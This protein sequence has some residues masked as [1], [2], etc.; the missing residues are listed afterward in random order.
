MPSD[1]QDAMRPLVLTPEEQ[2][3]IAEE[4]ERV[5]AETLATNELFVASGRKLPR[6]EWKRLKSKENLH[7]YR[8]RRTD[9]SEC[10]DG[11]DDEEDEEESFSS[12]NSSSA[13]PATKANP[14]ISSSSASS[15][16]SDSN[17]T[18]SV[19]G[20]MKPTDTPLVIAT[21]IIPGTVE[22]A[23]F[24]SQGHTP[25]LWRFRDAHM[26][27]RDDCMK[28]L[29]TIVSPTP[30][31]P[32][33][34]LS[35]KW[36]LN[37]INPLSRARD[38][39]YIEATGMARDARGEPFGYYLL[40]SLD[41]I[42][43]IPGLGHLDIVR[44]QISTC[45]ISRANDQSSFE[46]FC[47]GFSELG[48]NFSAT[49]GNA[50]YAQYLLN[51]VDVVDFAYI[52]KLLWLVHKKRSCGSA[53]LTACLSPEPSDCAIC[54]GKLSKL[55]HLLYKGVSCE[56]CQLAVCRKC[57]VVKKVP[58]DDPSS[59]QVT[60]KTLSFCVPC[61]IEAKEAPTDEVAVALMESMPTWC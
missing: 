19:I 1:P 22:D 51:A 38:A 20:I 53:A 60:M 34:S 11:D 43:R 30:E 5:I 39:V 61:M 7:V 17:T 48:G 8:S 44:A 3:A 49:L 47:R 10:V 12:T 45:C 23:V 16:K 6:H 40:H 33:K 4:A 36:V 25:Q 9:P 54:T 27:D 41:K 29:A 56:A 58:I 28:I 13:L 37:N 21:G 26:N 50:M 46:F 55:G 32:L 18:R 15:D 52:K 2:L 14:S 59:R 24:G 42:A 31:E 35:L 57:S